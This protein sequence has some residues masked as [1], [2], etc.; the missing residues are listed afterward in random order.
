[1]FINSIRT[2]LILIS[3]VAIL[4]FGASI[5]YVTLEK[6]ETLYRDSVQQNLAALSEN[7]ASDLVRHLAIDPQDID[8]IELTTLLL[9]LEKYHNVEYAKVFAKNWEEI[10]PYYSPKFMKNNSLEDAFD[11]NTLKYL[12]VGIHIYKGKLIAKRPVGEAKLTLGYLIIVTEYQKPIIQ[13]RQ[14]LLLGLLPYFSLVMLVT[15]LGLLWAHHR[16]LTPLSHLSSFAKRVQKTKDYSTKVPAVGVYEVAEL[17][18]NINKMMKTIHAEVNK[19][20]RY[21]QQ[22]IEQQKTM[23]RLANFDSLTGLPNRQFFMENVRIALARSK[24]YSSNIALMFFDLDGFKEVND[25]Y[26]HEVGDFLLIEVSERLKHCFRDE[27]IIARL[28]GD[29]FLILVNDEPDDLQLITIAERVI[30]QFKRPIMVKSWEVQIGVSIGIAHASDSNFNLSNFISNA[31]IAMYH[32]KAS[33]KGT[34]TMFASHMMEDAK[35]R[36]IIANSLAPAL[37]NDEFTLYYH[38]KVNADEEIVGYEIL[39]RWISKE[40]GFISPAEF[41]PIAEQTGKMSAVTQWVLKRMCI[42]MPTLLEVNDPPVSVA[43]NLSVYDLKDSNLINYIKDLFDEYRIDPKLIEFEITESAYLENF[44]KANAFF[45]QIKE[46]GSSLALDDF[47]T[48]YSSL[49]YLTQL[50]INTLKIDKQFVDNLGLSERDTLVIQTI[51]NMAH[52]LKLDICAE[53]VE[54]REQFDALVGYG[55]HQLQGYLFAKPVPLSDLTQRKS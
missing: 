47:G 32:S 53:G 29:E 21:T 16:F 51:I 42:E 31:D 45:E 28:G 41:I 50:P 30:E 24:R 2:N 4:C 44:E 19:N 35:R 14:S 11:T 39:L 15:F 48:G 34:Y 8:P 23:E 55:C 27:D 54:T 9:R 1:M 17:R 25:A 33:G 3:T 5:L 38:A 18:S 46:L 49:G 20:T 12:D 40:H 52:S 10:T 7:M 26:G 36:L 43:V 13:S 22:L 6:H 37:Q